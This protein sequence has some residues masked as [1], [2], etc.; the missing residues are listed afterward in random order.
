MKIADGHQKLIVSFLP[1]GVGSEVVRILHEEKEIN[2]ANV[3]GGRG[4]ST[5]GQVS[6]GNWAEIDILEV[7]V[8]VAREQEIFEFIYDTADMHKRHGGIIFVQ[9]LSRATSFALPL[10][11]NHEE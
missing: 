2:S 6:F 9:K 10:E 11:V 1:K 7:V 4:L 5:S 8:D 3:S